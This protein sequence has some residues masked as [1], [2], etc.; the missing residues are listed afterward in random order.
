M[1]PEAGGAVAESGGA[2]PGPGG[3]G[4][5]SGGARG[6]LTA[7]LLAGVGG[8]T[9]GISA[10]QTWARGSVRGPVGPSPVLVTGSA[11][12]PLATAAG[13]LGLAAVGALLATRRSARQVVGVLVVLAAVG[14][15]VAALRFLTDPGGAGYTARGLAGSSAPAVAAVTARP[16]TVTLT[17]WPWLTVAAAVLLLAAGLLTAVGGRGWPALGGRYEAPV[18]GSAAATVTTGGPLPADTAGSSDPAE[19]PDPPG[20]LEPPGQDATAGAPED[21]AEPAAPVRPAGMWDEL[22]AG[23][24]PTAPGG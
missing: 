8:A 6:L 20:S 19:P 13:I 24:D 15:G 17:A 18:V 12:A 10:T 22:D 21:P 4:R 14:A 3:A 7:V 23:R 1:T 2:A 11:A 16:D 5:R 9:A